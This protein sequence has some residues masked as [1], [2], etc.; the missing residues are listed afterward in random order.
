[1]DDCECDWSLGERTELEIKFKD[2]Q[3]G[4][5]DL[6]SEPRSARLGGDTAHKDGGLSLMPSAM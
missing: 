4:G 2:H 3:G 6:S 5:C 1:M